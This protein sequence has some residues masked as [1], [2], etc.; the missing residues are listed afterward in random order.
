MSMRAAKE[1]TK[2]EQKKETKEVSA[3]ISQKYDPSKKFPGK[4]QQITGKIVPEEEIKSAIVIIPHLI[5]IEESCSAR[6]R[7]RS[8]AKS[9]KLRCTTLKANISR[10]LVKSRLRK[11]SSRFQEKE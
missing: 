5:F 9:A 4:G 1:T 6:S 11:D 7:F 10:I 2:K 3:S 8:K